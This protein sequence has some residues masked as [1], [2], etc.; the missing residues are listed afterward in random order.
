[1]GV[2]SLPLIKKEFLV[3]VGGFDELMQSSQDYDLW[4]RIAKHYEFN[5][6]E[7]PLL[8]YYIHGGERVTTNV[9]KKI[10]GFE[11]LN[12]EYKNELEK[13]DMVWYMRHRCLIPFYYKKY[14]RRYSILLWLQ[15]VKK[16]PWQI[17]ENLKYFLRALIGPENYFLL[18]SKW[19]NLAGR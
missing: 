13:N 4:L 2:T 3:E 7:E 19:H 6:I 18:V 5:Y 9:D 17:V 11:R 14:G 8:N 12:Y 1:M 16:M 10:A 15:C